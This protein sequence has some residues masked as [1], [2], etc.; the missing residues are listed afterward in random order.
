MTRNLSTLPPEIIGEILDYLPRWRVLGLASTC[1]S[2]SACC[3]RIA[4]K[5]IDLHDLERV[6]SC[7]ETL[8]FNYTLAG[9]VREFSIVLD[10]RNCRGPPK[11]TFTP[12]FNRLLRSALQ[13]TST[14][15]TALELR[16]P[17]G[18]VNS[19]LKRMSFPQLKMFHVETALSADLAQFLLAHPDLENLRIMGPMVLPAKA[20]GSRGA[21]IAMSIPMTDLKKFAGPPGSCA[22]FLP[23]SKVN[24]VE[25]TTSGNPQG[26]DWESDF[27][28]AILKSGQPIRAVGFS[29]FI[30]RDVMFDLIG[31][32]LSNISKLTLGFTETDQVTTVLDGLAKV[33]PDLPHLYHLQ[34]TPPSPHRLDLAKLN[35]DLLDLD[36]TL[37]CQLT[38][39]RETLSVCDLL[40][41]VTWARLTDSG[42]WLP[43]FPTPVGI[44]WWFQR[45]PLC[46]HIQRR[47][48]SH[49]ANDLA[50]MDEDEGEDEEDVQP[51]VHKLATAVGFIVNRAYDIP[52]DEEKD[53]EEGSSDSGS[54]DEGEHEPLR[55]PVRNDKGQLVQPY[56]DGTNAE[57]W[58]M[59]AS[60]IGF[61]GLHP[62]PIFLQNMAMFDLFLPTIDTPVPLLNDAQKEL[63][64]IIMD[65]LY[66]SFN[67]KNGIKL[68]RYF[69]NPEEYWGKRTMTLGVAFQDAIIPISCLL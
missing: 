28:D 41:S 14:F 47:V 20:R 1:R 58:D 63:M 51:D 55:V 34:L 60:I 21:C 64:G 68:E 5:R 52:K 15:L 31:E 56:S 57:H 26:P 65:L 46:M 19:C 11:A 24:D 2:F 33:L 59:F 3:A 9:Y 32:R 69:R 16:M 23:G 6:K 48:I 53:E 62:A 29:D 39:R 50:D 40:T 25:I 44:H 17:N 27:V 45:T 42:D 38:H 12:Q 37:L 61:V 36:Y 43:L 22:I 30:Y 35:E 13:N 66:N 4:Y 8:A 18:N 54:E 49:L 10:P 67:E 7:C